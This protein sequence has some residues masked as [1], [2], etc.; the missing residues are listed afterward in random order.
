MRRT[1]QLQF[2]PFAGFSPRFLPAMMV[3]WLFPMHIAKMLPHV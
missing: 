3:E 2:G 1:N